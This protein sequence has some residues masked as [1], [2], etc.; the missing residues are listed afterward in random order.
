MPGEGSITW[1]AAGRLYSEYETTDRELLVVTQETATFAGGCFWCTEAIFVRLKGVESVTPGYTGGALANPTYEQVCSGRTGHAEAVQIVFDSEV[2][3]YEQLLQVFFELH[4]PT[5]L[6]RQGADVGTQYRS[7]V[8]Y[9]DDGQKETAERFKAEVES[10][11]HYRDKV[12]TEIAPYSEFYAAEAYHK[13]FYER[14][15]TY[16]YCNVVIDP[17]ITKLY[18]SF[19]EM[20]A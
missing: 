9:H 14:N 10:S 16:P 3:S 13:D 7:A 8:F 18:K 19:S 4:D 15:P 1:P 20:T 12:V 17:K 5:T 11:G 2:I 6:N